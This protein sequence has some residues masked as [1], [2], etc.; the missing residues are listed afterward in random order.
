MVDF[1]FRT[2]PLTFCFCFVSD[3]E[4]QKEKIT[5]LFIIKYWFVTQGLK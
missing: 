1:H 4:I 5:I 3:K 2:Q